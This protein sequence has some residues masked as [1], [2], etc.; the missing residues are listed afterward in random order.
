MA[1]VIV[2]NTVTKRLAAAG[3]TSAL[4][5]TREAVDKRLE[6]IAAGKGLRKPTSAHP[7]R[8]CFDGW[9]H[10]HWTSGRVTGKRGGANYTRAYGEPMTCA[11]HIARATGQRDWAVEA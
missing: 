1:T 7:F 4:P 9:T 2:R 11:E 10:V 8:E 3:A 5:T 6:A